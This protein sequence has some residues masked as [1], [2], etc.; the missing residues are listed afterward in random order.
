MGRSPAVERAAVRGGA[1]LGH[2]PK[3]E[4]SASLCDAPSILDEDQM[5]GIVVLVLRVVQM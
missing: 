2:A 5:K 4:A 3:I 1:W